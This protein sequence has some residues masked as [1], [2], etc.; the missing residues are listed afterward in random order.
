MLRDEEYGF[1]AWFDLTGRVLVGFE[2]LH[3][4]E[5]VLESKP[6]TRRITSCGSRFAVVT[7]RGERRRTWPAAM[8]AGSVMGWPGTSSARPGTSPGSDQ[9]AEMEAGCLG[10]TKRRM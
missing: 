4:D 5:P 9:R 7:A 8:E 2:L 6:S 1:T 3:D 10:T